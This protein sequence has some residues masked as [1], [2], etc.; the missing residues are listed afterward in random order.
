MRETAWFWLFK[1]STWVTTQL[2]ERLDMFDSGAVVYVVPAEHAD[3]IE[4]AILS[5][6]ENTHRN[7]NVN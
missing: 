1:A 5:D 4:Q 7:R 6:T 2:A 3:R